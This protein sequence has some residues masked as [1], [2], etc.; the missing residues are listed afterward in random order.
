MAAWASGKSGSSSR[1]FTAA[2]RARAKT[3]G[4][5]ASEWVE[6]VEISAEAAA[7]DRDLTGVHRRMQRHETRQFPQCREHRVRFLERLIRHPDFV[8]A[9]ID[10]G[11]I[12]GHLAELVEEP[13]LLGHVERS[14]LHD[15]HIGDLDRLRRVERRI[16]RAFEDDGPGDR[17]VD[18]GGHQLRRW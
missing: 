5:G 8:A 10:T 17:S 1:A 6:Y 14:E 15:R 16:W 11:F 13:A 4:G 2:S 18:T 3:P 12:D 9:R 7:D